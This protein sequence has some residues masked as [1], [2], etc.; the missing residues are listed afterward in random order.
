MENRSQVGPGMA[1][2]EALGRQYG[3]GTAVSRALGRHVGHGMAVSG[4]LGR[5]VGSG[6][7]VSGAL[8]HLERP[9]GHPGVQKRTSNGRVPRESVRERFFIDFWSFCEVSEPSEVPHLSAKT[10]VR[11]F[12]LSVAL[13]PRKT[14]KI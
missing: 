11:P 2:L 6:T 9:Q 13:K 12:A 8:G 4:T 7:A 10:G 1:V 14:K 3:S 5:Q